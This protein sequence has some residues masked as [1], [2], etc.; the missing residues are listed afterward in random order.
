M[1]GGKLGPV[2]ASLVIVAPAG[3]CGGFVLLKLKRAQEW[4]CA[5]ATVV[6]LNKTPLTA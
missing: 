6:P 5:Q 1:A 3:G 2:E 4:S